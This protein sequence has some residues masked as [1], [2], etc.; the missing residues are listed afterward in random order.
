MPF[1]RSLPAAIAILC[2]LAPSA[3]AADPGKATGTITI[4]GTTTTLTLAA[5]STAENLFDSKKSDTIITL[6]DRPLGDA[7]AG[8]DVSLSMR[9]RKG[10]LVV[11]MLRIDGA[12]L[13]NVSLMYKGLSGVE[14]LP[15][16][17]FT[18]AATGKNTGT[19]KLVKK[20]NDGHTYASDLVFNAAPAAAATKTEDAPASAKAKAADVP[21]PASSTSSL[22][23][24]AAMDLFVAAMMQKDEHQAVALVKSGV[25]PNLKDK[26]GIAMLN[27]AVMTCM[28]TVVQALVD[29]K[30]SL[31]YQRVPGFTILME[32]GA[33]PEAAKILKAAGA[34]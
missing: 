32:A 19:L 12:R 27:W 16:Q 22:S 1:R 20:E 3:R 5:S 33:C 11:V 14:K 25:D 13:V 31:T 10:D 21:L 30:A 29:R 23:P 4:D 15:G 24:K 18:Y 8:D 9:A 28:P 17:W 6:T 34:K 2:F 7:Q 26:D